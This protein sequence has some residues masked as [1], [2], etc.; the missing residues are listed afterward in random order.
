[1]D[2]YTLTTC[3]VCGK[4][5][6]SLSPT[7]GQQQVLVTVRNEGGVQ[8][9]FDILPLAQE[10]A[11]LRTYP[12]ERR[13]RAFLGF[14]AEGDVDAIVHLIRDEPDEDDE[15]WDKG[16]DVLRF[17]GGREGIMTV[18]GSGLHVAIENGR[19]DVAW[20]LLFLGSGLALEEFPKE[21]LE[22]AKKLGLR[23]EDRKMETGGDIRGLKNSEGLDAEAFAKK[24]GG[25]EWEEWVASGRLRSP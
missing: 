23:V 25:R 6:S 18:D 11:Y 22:G 1:M 13:G 2:S 7:T 24:F 12:E 15:V 4:D 10:E 21:V 14:C 3:P 8:E 17:T 5:I 16:V 20:L 19:V 9:N